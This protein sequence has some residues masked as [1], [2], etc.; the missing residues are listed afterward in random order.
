MHARAYALHARAPRAVRARWCQHHAARARMP[1]RVR[2]A[3]F[4][5]T[6]GGVQDDDDDVFA[7]LDAVLGT[8]ST[9]TPND[10]VDAA[11]APV[12]TPKPSQYADRA[13]PLDGFEVADDWFGLGPKWDVPFGASKTFFT[14]LTID[15]TFYIAGFLAPIA[16][17]S[18]LRDPS[19]IPTEAEA[20]TTDLQNVFADPTSFS[21]IFL[22]AEV[23][24][25]VLGAIV[26][27]I[28]LTPHAPLPKGWFNDAF[29]S[30]APEH[31]ATGKNASRARRMAITQAQDA[32]R[33]ESSKEAG[34]AILGTLVS[35]SVITALL[36]LT[37]LRGG[38]EQ[39]GAASVDIIE[40]AFAAGPH[41]VV[42]LI[43]TTVVLAP[44]FEEIIFRG[45]LLPSLTKYM[46]PSFAIAL[47][48][49]IFALIHQH[50]IGDTVQ[51]LAVGVAC[52]VVY[53]RT[54]NLGASMLVHAAFNGTVIALFAL[55]TA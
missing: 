55:W 27:G 47:S 14:M 24:Q 48:A 44:V 53:S 31:N 35:V 17:Y 34:K 16:V 21:D 54:R 28:S 45:Y 10:D 30:D 13:D 32:R 52:G 5:N 15:A 1:S 39:T 11:P 36:Y 18:T 20:L 43:L 51:L 49:V 8:P 29:S 6:D 40:K 22:T 42:N 4:E 2:R 50:G 26:L 12:M 7:A 37:G 41:G 33:A 9:A 19:D 46:P 23:M 38:E 25:I 3:A